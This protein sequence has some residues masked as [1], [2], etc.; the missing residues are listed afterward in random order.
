VD[1]LPVVQLDEVGP[2]EVLRHNLL[3]VRF[4]FSPFLTLFFPTKI[5]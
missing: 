1:V 4:G 5:P 3:K 2:A